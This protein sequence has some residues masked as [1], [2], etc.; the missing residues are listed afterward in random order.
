MR[1]S[2]RFVGVVCVVAATTMVAGACTKKGEESS[3]SP[4]PGATSAQ[5]GGSGEKLNSGL[6]GRVNAKSWPGDG[7]SLGCA[8]TELPVLR[9]LG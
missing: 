3:S 1:I 8:P 5:A 4:S 6:R 7:T 9:S 2:R